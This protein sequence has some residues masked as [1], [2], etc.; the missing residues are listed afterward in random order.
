MMEEAISYWSGET[1]ATMK[2]IIMCP[3]PAFPENLSRLSYTKQWVGINSIKI[4]R[5][6]DAHG[7]W[8]KY[9]NH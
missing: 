3:S 2:R 6:C 1:Q 9:T 7:L 8:Q 4:P 5:I